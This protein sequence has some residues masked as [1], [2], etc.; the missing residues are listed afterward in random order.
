[1]FNNHKKLKVKLFKEVNLNLFNHK[2]NMFK[3]VNLNLLNK[4]QF[5]IFKEDNLN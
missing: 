1:M 3:E 4:V 2:F 5:N